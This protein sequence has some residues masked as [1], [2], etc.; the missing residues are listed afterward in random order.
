MTLDETYILK[1]YFSLVSAFSSHLGPHTVQG[2]WEVLST[3]LL[4]EDILWDFISRSMVFISVAQ[5]L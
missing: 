1:S 3:Q 4:N 5:L 2:T